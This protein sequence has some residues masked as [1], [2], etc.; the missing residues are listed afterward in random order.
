MSHNET[1]VVENP[2]TMDESGKLVMHH[3]LHAKID[4]AYLYLLFYT[5]IVSPPCILMQVSNVVVGVTTGK[6]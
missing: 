5:S 1:V 3:C 4:A 6:K 2:M